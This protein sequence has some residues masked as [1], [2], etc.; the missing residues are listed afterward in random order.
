MKEE[1]EYPRTLNVNETMMWCLGTKNPLKVGAT[2]ISDTILILR[3]VNEK[4]KNLTLKE[5]I[6]LDKLGLLIKKV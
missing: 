3:A 4:N 1:N 2:Q 5:E 6:A